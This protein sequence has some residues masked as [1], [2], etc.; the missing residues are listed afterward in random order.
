[1]KPTL[2]ASAYIAIAHVRR[3]LNHLP[4]MARLTT[5]RALCPRPRVSV[6]NTSNPVA[7]AA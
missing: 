3:R 7:L 2:I 5:E 6:M 4:T 1:M